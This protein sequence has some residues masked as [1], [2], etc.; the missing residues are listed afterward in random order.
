MGEEDKGEGARK[1]AGRNAV[2]GGFL[3]A[4]VRVLYRNRPA[5]MNILKEDIY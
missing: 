3:G 5:W 4:L 1:Q 2:R